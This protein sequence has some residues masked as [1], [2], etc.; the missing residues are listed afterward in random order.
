MGFYKG[1]KLHLLATGKDEIIPLAW[2]FSCANEHDSQK[3]EF[4]SRA[5]VYGAKIVLADAGYSSREMVQDSSR[6]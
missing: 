4:L 1:Y 3:I 5:C 6:V 2:E